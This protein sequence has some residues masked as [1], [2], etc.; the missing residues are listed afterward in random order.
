MRCAVDA[1]D[2]SEDIG[3]VL[4]FFQK[5]LGTSVLLIYILLLILFHFLNPSC[6]ADY[7][8]EAHGPPVGGTLQFGNLWIR[9]Q[10]SEL[11]SNSMDIFFL[12]LFIGLWV[13]I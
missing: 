3:T 7:V 6:S 13:A 10:A 4:N 8:I 1:E 2:E 12:V 11:N 5:Y 9:R